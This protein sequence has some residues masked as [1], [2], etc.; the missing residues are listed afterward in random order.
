MPGSESS[1]PKTW[2]YT[3]HDEVETAAIGAAIGRAARAG[4][5]IALVGNLG[6]GKTRLTRAVAKALEVDEKLVTSPT[7]VL[8]QEYAGRLPV[9]HFDTYRLGSVDEFLDLGVE[10]Y[11]EAGGVCLIEWADRV[12]GV[13]PDDVLRIEI[14]ITGES[15]R[16]FKFAAHGPIAQSILNDVTRNVADAHKEG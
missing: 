3:S 14:D 5:V 7:F 12:A 15:T 4:A 11:F 8:I 6:A 1:F 16:V 9:F 13:L 2:T 10:E